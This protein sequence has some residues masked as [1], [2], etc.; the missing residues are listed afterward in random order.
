MQVVHERV[1]DYECQQQVDI[2]T[3]RAFSSLTD[4]VTSS[5]HLLLEHGR[6]L[7]MKGQ[8]PEEEITAL[9]QEFRVIAIHPLTVPGASIKRHVIDIRRKI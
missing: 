7:A 1:E 2:V 9:P 8:V 5:Q 4:F 6:F 3:S